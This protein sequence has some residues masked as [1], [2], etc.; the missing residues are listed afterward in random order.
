MGDALTVNRREFLATGL[1]AAGALPL[2]AQDPPA[3]L[4]VHEW[5]VLCVVQGSNW[6]TTAAAGA[7]FD[8]RKAE[9]AAYSLDFARTWTAAVG[10]IIEEWESRPR[11][12][13]KPLIYFYCKDS[14]LVSVTVRVP[15]GRPSVWWPPETEF[16]PRP[17]VKP[18]IEDWQEDQPMQRREEI[19]PKNGLLHWLNLQIDPDADPSRF[20][21]SP[22]DHWW[23]LARQTDSCPVIA[24]RESERFL[25]YDA[26]T[27]VEPALAVDWIAPDRVRL[28][29]DGSRTIPLVV[30]IR[31]LDG[32]LRAAHLLDLG[33]GVQ[34]DLAPADSWSGLAGL[35]ER[36]GLYRKEAEGLQRIWT[37]EFFQTDGHR[38]IYS[39]PRPQIDELLPLEVS[40]RP[41][42]T[43]RVLLVQIESLG[44]ERAEQL[45]GLIERLGEEDPEEREKAAGEIRKLGSL[46]E[47]PLRHAAEEASDPEIRSRAAELLGLVE[48]KP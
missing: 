30:A 11:V 13:F 39:M 7:P 17:Q 46:A 8:A 44:P 34:R 27:P 9:K 22:Q 6:A 38:V 4:T 5:G 10:K 32:K 33:P 26:L 12:V 19:T 24:G 36:E 1:A 37:R 28:R 43:V 25:F 2:L 48:F 41:A 16:E 3:G 14:Q 29:N 31:V 42:Q 40:P 20:R 45:R 47:G 35:L 23:H 15:K 21:P 18:P